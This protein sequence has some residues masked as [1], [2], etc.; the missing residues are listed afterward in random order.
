MDA[1]VPIIP[2]KVDLDFPP[3]VPR[4][5]AGDPLLTRTLDGL[6]LLFPAGEQFFIR[7]VQNFRDR[8][9]DPELRRQMK[10]FAYQEAQHSIA[11][12]AFNAHLEAQGVRVA[13]VEKNL[14][15]RL[16]FAERH[17]SEVHRLA[18]TMSVEHLTAVFAEGLLAA[19][20]DQLADADPRMRA[21]YLWHAV[22]EIEH[23]AVSW[24]VYER[25]ARGSYRR[26]LFMHFLTTL[27]I[28]ANVAVAAAYLLWRDGLLFDP[29][30]WRRGLPRLWGRRGFFRPLLRP[31][32]RGFRRGF[33][34]WTTEP[35]RQFA[36]FVRA[37]AERPDILAASAAATGHASWKLA[38]PQPSRCA[39]S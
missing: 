37:Y 3:T 4:H 33:H 16:S 38:S 13:W 5:W 23:K 7:S 30:T 22:E 9:D 1:A 29:G 28:G 14:R 20:D 26:R 17:L 15:A 36:E 27:A 11:H 12:E 25:V 35:P 24:D 31:Y 19:M 34:P 21:L 32:F 6:S 18:M 2:R 10:E 39:S 8:V